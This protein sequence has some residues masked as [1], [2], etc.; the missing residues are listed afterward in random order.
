MLQI[1][2]SQLWGVGVT[3]LTCR[4]FG[5]QVMLIAQ[6]MLAR[7]LIAEIRAR[8]VR[9]M[10]SICAMRVPESSQRKGGLGMILCEVK[11]NLYRIRTLS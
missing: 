5:A 2:G 8:A 1:Y 10:P 9:F 11:S 4:I 7:S 3:L 6:N